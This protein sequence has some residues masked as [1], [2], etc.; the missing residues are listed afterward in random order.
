MRCPNRRRIFLRL[1]VGCCEHN[2]SCA[3]QPLTPETELQTKD[4]F[5]G[6]LRVGLRLQRVYRRVK[7]PKDEAEETFYEALNAH[8]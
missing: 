3:H 8:E 2:Q 7:L 6:I 1:Q 5:T 4:C